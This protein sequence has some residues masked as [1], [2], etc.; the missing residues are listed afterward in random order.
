MAI[1]H[2]RL[3]CLKAVPDTWDPRVMLGLSQAGGHC[4]RKARRKQAYLDN[5]ILLAELRDNGG[6]HVGRYRCPLIHHENQGG[7]CRE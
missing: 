4:Q 1:A 7:R 6:R 5:N 3:H 2:P